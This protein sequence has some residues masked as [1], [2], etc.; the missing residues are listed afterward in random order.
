M[1]VN[2]NARDGRLSP[3]LAVGFYAL[4]GAIGVGW[5]RASGDATF[6]SAS[7][8]GRHLLVAVGAGALAALPL[9]GAGALLERRVRSLRALAR[10]IRETF[11]VLRHRDVV[12]YSL[13]SAVGEELLFRGAVLPSLGLAASALLFGLAHGFFQRRY[14]AWSL[15]AAVTGVLLGALTLWTGTL[16]AAIVCHATVNYASLSDLIPSEAPAPGDSGS[17]NPEG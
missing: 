6:L 11:G 5:A 13:S 10:E 2:G 4:L 17:S 15:Y 16:V 1:D 12:V 14:R 7:P 8:D 3:W 9:I